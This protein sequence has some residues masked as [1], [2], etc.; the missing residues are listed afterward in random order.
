M[1][2]KLGCTGGLA[3]LSIPCMGGLP[4]QYLEISAITCEKPITRIKNVLHKKTSV[5]C[6]ITL[7]NDDQNPKVFHI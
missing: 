3:T 1:S 6:K 4:G 5:F 2:G 7:Y